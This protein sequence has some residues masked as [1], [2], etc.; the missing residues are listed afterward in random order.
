MAVV[1]GRPDSAKRWVAARGRYVVRTSR[2]L[3][4]SSTDPQTPCYR[5]PA[6]ASYSLV[7][8][9]PIFIPSGPA[10]GKDVVL[11]KILAASI[12]ALFRDR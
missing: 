9:L 12:P 10:V 11:A 7:L 6:I 3:I 4:K 2:P 8:R 1:F 5:R